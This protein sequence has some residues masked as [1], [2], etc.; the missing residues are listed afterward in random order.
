MEIDMEPLHL[1]TVTAG[2]GCAVLRVGGEVDVYSAPQLRERVIQLVADG[3]RHIVADLREVDFLDSTGLGAL[4][5]SL[6]RL[7]EQDGSLRLVTRAGRIPQLF[8]IT[9]LDR[10][11][12]LHPSVP[13]AIT[14]D[15]HWTA[16]LTA[17]GLSSEDWCRKH[18]LL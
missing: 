9:G 3:I 16:A 4:V 1:E 6:K 17:E 7:R 12:A 5:G 2:V 14:G 11:F 10:V 15:Q 8:S 18:A 13:E